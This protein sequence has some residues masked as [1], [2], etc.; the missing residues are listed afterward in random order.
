MTRELLEDQWDV[1][2]GMICKGDRHSGIRMS[3]DSS[4][5]LISTGAHVNDES[6]GGGG[7]KAPRLRHMVSPSFKS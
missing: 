6:G 2:R 4:S 7:G 1:G 5:S 3:G